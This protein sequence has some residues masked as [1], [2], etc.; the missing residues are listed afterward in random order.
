MQK[1]NVSPG[2]YFFKEE[3]GKLYFKHKQFFSNGERTIV[4]FELKN[5][6]AYEKR[7]IS[8]CACWEWNDS[9][10][11]LSEVHEANEQIKAWEQWAS[12]GQQQQ[13]GKK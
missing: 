1:L 8:T 13:K 9:V 2:S 10:K 6:S 3:N 7:L 5:V 4:W 11:D 12:E